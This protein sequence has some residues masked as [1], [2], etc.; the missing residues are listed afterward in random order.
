MRLSIVVITLSF[1]LI[2][3][4]AQSQQLSTTSN[5][6]AARTQPTPI[7][8]LSP[9][10]KNGSE[11]D[12]IEIDK[13]IIDETISKAGYDFI[14]LFFA[15]WNWP[16]QIEGAFII[17]ITERPFRGI[18]TQILISVNDLQVFDSFLQTRYDYLE[19]IAGAA[20]DQTTAYIV[21]YEEIVKQLGGEDVSG[22]GIF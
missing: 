12:E 11:L 15:Q 17:V 7:D 3:Q 16:P 10:S 1:Y 2:A 20:I 4:A 13:L 21:N 5:S 18:S 19:Y 9:A 14:E 22:S 8:T 6:Q